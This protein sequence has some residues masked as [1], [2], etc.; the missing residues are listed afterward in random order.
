MYKPGLLK[1]LDPPCGSMDSDGVCDEW[2]E[3]HEHSV[4]DSRT[5]GSRYRT[6]VAPE[7]C[8][9]LPHSCDQWVIGGEKEIEALIKDLKRALLTNQSSGLRG[10][11]GP[12]YG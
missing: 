11:C 3:G 6:F 9:Y 4:A 12:K 10:C 1:H 5:E 8:F 7:I 2:G